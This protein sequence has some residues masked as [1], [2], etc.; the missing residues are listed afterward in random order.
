MACLIATFYQI[1]QLN[2]AMFNCNILPNHTIK[3]GHCKIVPNH[4]IKRGRCNIVSNYTIIQ[5]PFAT[6]YPK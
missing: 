6:F 1:I 4:T 5:G 2:L 3:H